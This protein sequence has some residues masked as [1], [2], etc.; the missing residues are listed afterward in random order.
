MAVTMS[1][2]TPIL[3]EVYEGDV[4]RQLNDA[5]KAYARLE[6]T[7]QGVA[8]KPL[9]GKYVNFSIH[10]RR[11]SGIGARNEMEALPTP[12]KQKYAEGTVNL[13]YQYA[14]I[15][16]SGQL[17]Q[18]AS[19]KYQAFA[20]AVDEE[21]ERIK[22]DLEVDRNRQFWGDG[23]GTVATVVSVAGQVITVNDAKYVQLDEVL[24]IL[25]TAG[26]SVVQNVVVTGVDYDAN[27]V[28]VTGT[29]TGT[30]A[31]NIL[32]RDG[33][34]NREWTGIGAIVKDTG[35]LYGI[36]PATEPVWKSPVI[37]H[38]SNITEAVMKRAVDRISKVGGKTT[39]GWYTPGVERAY[40]QLLAGQ[41]QFTNPKEY[42]GGY[43]GLSFNAGSSGEIPLLT[44]WDAPKGTIHFLNEKEIKLY[45]KQG[46]KFLD[47]DG[48]MWYRKID[49]SGRYDAYGAD[50]YEYS[51]LGTKR[52]N[53][54]GKITGITEDAS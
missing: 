27:T 41:R 10:T 42:N 48:S 39:V 13:K 35:S 16:V 34:W 31:D 22:T 51:E 4:N 15:E 24:D 7:S 47:R 28:T 21:I 46:F 23:S 29:L 6:S 49:A 14:G 52:R 30:A 40:W 43:T 44:D 20:N 5:K 33:S 37:A 18:L 45:R 17:F 19:E 26:A 9:G 36:D 53:T 2:L 38:N 12:G 11:N 8:D 54:H 50:L 1:D 3:K 25:T 32:V